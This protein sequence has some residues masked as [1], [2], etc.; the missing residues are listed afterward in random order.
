MYVLCPLCKAAHA[1]QL[2]AVLSLLPTILNQLLTLLVNCSSEDVGLNIIRLLV[3][4][5]NMVHDAGRQELLKVYVK[6]Y[7]LFVQ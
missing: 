3:N 2:S 1:V 7:L 5:V 4:I 6:V